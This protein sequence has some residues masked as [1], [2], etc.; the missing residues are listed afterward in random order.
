Q[1]AFFIRLVLTEDRPCI[2]LACGGITIMCS[3]HGTIGHRVLSAGRIGCLPWA[4]PAVVAQPH[5]VP[6]FPVRIAQWG[7][8]EV[9][10]FYCHWPMGWH[11]RKTAHDV[12]Q[13]IRWA[14]MAG[15]FVCIP[16]SQL[17][18]DRKIEG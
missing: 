6:L 8:H 7:R 12:L 2:G 5:C 11:C 4:Q 14:S 9:V 10:V 3:H 17:L 13:Y 18:Y 1:L 15:L 16:V